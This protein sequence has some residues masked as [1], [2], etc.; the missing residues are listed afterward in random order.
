MSRS[1]QIAPVLAVALLTLPTAAR[2]Q[3]PEVGPSAS[4]ESAPD[5]GSMATRLADVDSRMDRLQ[6]DLFA[7]RA[8]LTLMMPD[9]MGA[10]GGARVRIVHADEM[11]SGFRLVRLAYALDGARVFVRSDPRGIARSGELEIYAGAIVAGTHVV[12]VELEYAGDGL[13]VFTYYER[14]YRF[15]VRSSHTFEAAAGERVD[16]RVVGMEEGGPLA[17][18]SERPG[19]RYVDDARP[20]GER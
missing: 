2:A 5:A 13:G 11:S 16:V 12:S 8:R 6:A 7:T 19:V 3:S 14:G 10:G 9:G 17:P 15:R 4:T 18:V 20:L 1:R